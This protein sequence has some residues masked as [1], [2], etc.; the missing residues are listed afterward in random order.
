MPWVPSRSTS[1]SGSSEP[2]TA[3]AARASGKC[4]SGASSLRRRSLTRSS[5]GWQR[6]RS[7][8]G[9]LGRSAMKRRSLPRPWSDEDLLWPSR[10]AWW[11][12]RRTRARNRRR[13]PPSSKARFLLRARCL[14]SGRGPK[15]ALPASPVPPGRP[16]TAAAPAA[17]PP[18]RPRRP[19]SRWAPRR[20]R[21][22]RCGRLGPMPLEMRSRSPSQAWLRR[23]RA[24]NMGQVARPEAMAGPAV[25]R[26][27]PR[28]RRS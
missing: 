1:S 13:R 23:P 14:H 24:R 3:G 6:K 27:R 12:L 20:H 8:R 28:S 22:A 19:C 21:P 25:R 15:V 17:P 16:P 7:R 11:P 4:R 5:R 18:A 10:G 2:R 26:L 9:W